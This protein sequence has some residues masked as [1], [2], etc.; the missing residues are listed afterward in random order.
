MIEII[1]W[2][3]TVEKSLRKFLLTLQKMFNSITY[4][5]LSSNV[6]CN[7][8]ERVDIGVCRKYRM[9]ETTAAD[10]CLDIVWVCDWR[11]QWSVVE[12]RCVIGGGWEENACTYNN[13]A[14]VSRGTRI[15]SD[16]SLGRKEEGKN[17]LYQ[18]SSWI[19]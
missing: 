6:L 17:N 11:V 10:E 15:L 3:A 8:D 16:G 4:R 13:Y 12:L 5:V 19:M 9:C 18:R 2:T 14:V 1:K 7:N